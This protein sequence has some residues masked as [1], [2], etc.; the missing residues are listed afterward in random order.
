LTA[1]HELREKAIFLKQLDDTQGDYL[2]SMEYLMVRAI[3]HQERMMA[4]NQG[5]EHFPNAQ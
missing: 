2:A 5:H 3:G 1:R 4:V